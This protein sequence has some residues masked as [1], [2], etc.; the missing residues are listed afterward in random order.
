MAVTF[1]NGANLSHSVVGLTMTNAFTIGAGANRLLLV[2]VSFMRTA[3][4]AAYVSSVTYNG[5]SLT[6]FL[7][8]EGSIAT[9][10]RFE[11]W[12]LLEASMPAAGAH[13]VTATFAWASA[14][15]AIGLGAMSFAG[16]DQNLWWQSGQ[17]TS[18]E[19]ANAGGA[20]SDPYTAYAPDLYGW[21]MG[22]YYDPAIL[23]GVNTPP[24][25]DLTSAGYKANM[26]SPITGGAQSPQ[27][28]HM[29]GYGTC[30]AGTITPTWD[31]SN[32]GAT[33]SW[34]LVSTQIRG[35]GNPTPHPSDP[36]QQFYPAQDITD[37]L[38]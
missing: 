13:N 32:G 24:V 16:V 9:H 20:I 1:D 6:K 29:G 7:V 22:M 37:L 25:T 12:T 15:V 21:H 28:W 27:Y 33:A 5:V 23:S 10:Y 38:A 17:S 19:A 34:F 36:W 2:G 4:N 3:A 30:A 14:P 18:G 26:E 8:S 31:I 11:V 35:L